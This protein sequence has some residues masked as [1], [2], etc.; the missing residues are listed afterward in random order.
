MTAI[1]T[2]SSSGSSGAFFSGDL[3]ILEF[4]D[5]L[6]YSLIST[7]DQ[8]VGDSL[9]VAEDKFI[10]ELSSSRNWSG[11]VDSARVVIDQGQLVLTVE[12]EQA[13][14]LEYGLGRTPPDP[15]LRKSVPKVAKEFE[16][17]VNQKVNG[18]NHV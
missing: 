18:G 12:S 13:I 6:D 7:I 17:A 2:H 3:A 15:A 11:L 10:E 16:K 14:N 5:S 1:P 9:E 8:A 4:V